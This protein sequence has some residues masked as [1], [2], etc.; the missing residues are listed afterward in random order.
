MSCTHLRH[1]GHEGLFF[2][3]RA[4][5]L[6]GD[7]DGHT[8]KRE[9][10]MTPIGVLHIPHSAVEIPADVRRQ[11]LVSDETLRQEL[12]KMTDWFTDELFTLPAREAVAIRFPVSRLVLD[13]ERF[14]DDQQEVMASRGMG[15]ID[16]RY[17]AT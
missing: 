17:P 12:L 1:P 11:F 8:E 6:S 16:S 14:I 4:V 13:P 7:N 2:E 9:S 5:L 15:V 10:E 3:A